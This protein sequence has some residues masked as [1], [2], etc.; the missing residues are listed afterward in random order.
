MST[1]VISSIYFQTFNKILANIEQI[2]LI[3]EKFV[4]TEYL[5]SV[6]SYKAIYWK[7]SY[8]IWLKT[9]VCLFAFLPF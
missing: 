2:Y 4:S 3:D 5:M 7:R 8:F 1:H 6:Y 9:I